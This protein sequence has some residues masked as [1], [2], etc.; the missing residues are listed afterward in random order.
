M[1]VETTSKSFMVICS[2]T[3]VSISIHH[4]VHLTLSGT[5]TSSVQRDSRELGTKI[6]TC[7]FE[8]PPGHGQHRYG[9]Y[10][11]EWRERIPHHSNN[12][13]E[14]VCHDTIVARTQR[15]CGNNKTGVDRWSAFVG[16]WKSWVDAGSTRV[17]D[18]IVRWW[19][20]PWRQQIP[21]T[22]TEICCRLWHH[23]QHPRFGR[24][25]QSGQSNRLQNIWVCELELAFAIN[26]ASWSIYNIELQK[27]R[28][29]LSW[30][31]WCMAF[32]AAVIRWN[33]TRRSHTNCRRSFESMIA[34]NRFYYFV[35]HDSVLSIHLMHYWFSRTY[36]ALAMEKSRFWSYW[37]FSTN[38]TCCIIVERCIWI[39]TF[40]SAFR[41]INSG[42]RCHA[43]WHFIMRAWQK[44][45]EFW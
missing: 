12:A 23:T 15:N 25:D 37:P 13:R 28:G 16:W 4:N 26:K 14:M 38:V 33:L 30:N 11:S 31:V 39:T 20:G 45:I 22:C 7:S 35:R 34:E 21:R 17:S 3:F 27:I 2:I 5:N 8:M 10:G 1:E 24:M 42:R 19:I 36:V 9:F 29:R 6:W 32:R 43:E 44:T 40:I 41:T 18:E